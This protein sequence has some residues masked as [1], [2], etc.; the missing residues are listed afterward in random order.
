MYLLYGTFENKFFY[1]L[2]LYTCTTFMYTK[3]LA[4]I[5]LGEGK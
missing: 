1:M 5:Y 3:N 4:I 2:V